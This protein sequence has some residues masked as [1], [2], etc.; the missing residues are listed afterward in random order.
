MRRGTR[1]KSGHIGEPTLEEGG[2]A[3]E[4]RKGELQALGGEYTTEYPNHEGA[5]RDP[6]EAGR[7]QI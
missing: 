5:D 6:E 2:E 3:Q 7:H 4:T 1:P